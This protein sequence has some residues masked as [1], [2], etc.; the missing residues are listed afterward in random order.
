MIPKRI[1]TIIITPS[2]PPIP[3]HNTMA[4]KGSKIQTLIDKTLHTRKKSNVSA[5]RT[6][7]QEDRGKTRVL[8]NEFITS[9]KV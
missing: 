3:P 7:K 2:P 5:T 1:T 6:Q 9:H 8:G 4:T